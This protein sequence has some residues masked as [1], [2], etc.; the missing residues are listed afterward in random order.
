MS[1]GDQL[2]DSTRSL[3]RLLRGSVSSSLGQRVE[4]LEEVKEEDIEAIQT[5]SNRICSNRTE[6]NAMSAHYW[7]VA[8]YMT[9]IVESQLAV[10]KHQAVVAT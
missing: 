2:S 5:L 4:R 7:A 6:A 3:E 1:Q 10:A 8:Y 9:Q